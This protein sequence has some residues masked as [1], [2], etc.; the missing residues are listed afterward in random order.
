MLLCCDQTTLEQMTELNIFCYK[1]FF[2]YVFII[3]KLSNI[4]T[5][6]STNV[7]LHHGLSALNCTG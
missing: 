1:K 4:P 6:F 5:Y 7:V 2:I 3:L